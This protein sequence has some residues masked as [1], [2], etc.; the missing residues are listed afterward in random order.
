MIYI[1]VLPV[2]PIMTNCYIL[3]DEKA[4][5]IAV[6]DPGG[7]SETLLDYLDNSD[8]EL[9]YVILTH[10]HY[11]HIGYAN[12]L[13][14]RY[15]AQIVCGRL[16]NEFL[17]D[18][19]LNHSAYHPDIP[20]IEPFKGDILLSDGDT[21]KLGDT[22]IKYIS[23]PGHTKDSGCYIF[24]NMIIAGDTLFRESYGRTDLPTGNDYE[25]ISS[26]KRLKNLDG[27]YNIMS[28]HGMASTL[29]HERMYNPLMSRL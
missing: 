5:V 18:N 28:G 1:K 11:D 2:G 23:T 21:F 16:T 7:K 13:A 26:L 27:E 29:N 20:D 22:E 4:G 10:G 9:K 19:E 17:C 3:T 8:M 6:V 12:Q 15:N 14:K 25:M 24:D